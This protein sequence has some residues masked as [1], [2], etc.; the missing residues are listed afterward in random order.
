MALTKITGEG[1]GTLSSSGATTATF[2]RTT[3]DGAI[4]DVQKDGTTVGNIGARAG[5]LRIGSGDTGLLFVS[6]TDSIHPENIDGGA[7]RDGAIDI[8]VAGARFRNLYLSGGAYIGGTGSANYLDDYEE[9]TFTP[10][11]S[12]AG[13][14]TY[15]AQVGRYT[16]IGNRVIANLYLIISNKSTMSGTQKVSGLPFTSENTSNNYNAASIWFNTMDGASPFNGNQSRE[17]FQVPNTTNIQIYAGNGSGGLH[18][19]DTSHMTNS[20]DVMLTVSYNV[21]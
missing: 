5:Y 21:S 6:G 2:N 10:I 19:L 11:W 3:S 4:I 18:Q 8:G 16:K 7:D 20:T 15:S 14:P 1:V 17:A 12:G 9:G 13:A